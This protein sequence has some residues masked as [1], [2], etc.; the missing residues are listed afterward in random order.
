MRAEAEVGPTGV[1]LRF[2]GRMEFAGGVTGEFEC[3]IAMPETSLL[4]VT[5]EAGRCGWT[6]RGTGA[7]QASTRTRCSSRTSSERFASA[8]RRWLPGEEIVRQAAA[9]EALMAS[10]GI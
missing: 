8:V 1:D 6:I 3:G 2:L 9:L 10:A 4:E 7:G 5:G